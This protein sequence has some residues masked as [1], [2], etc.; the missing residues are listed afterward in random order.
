MLALDE[1]SQKKKH[2]NVMPVVWKRPYG[3]G[4]VF[5]STLGHV[6]SDFEVPEAKEIMKRGCIWAAR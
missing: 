4:K 1:S 3:E 2:I 5:Y 6:A